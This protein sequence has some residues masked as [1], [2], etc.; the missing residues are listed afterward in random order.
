[1]RP[2]PLGVAALI[3][4]AGC[5][6]SQTGGE[7]RP[8]SP[9]SPSPQSAETPEPSPAPS[10]VDPR[11]EGFDIGFGEFAMALEAPAIRPG[12]V[13]F[14][15]RNGG[16][17]VHGF[18][19]EAEEEGGSSGPGGGDEGRFKVERP[20]F[21]PGETIRVDLD[22]SPGVYKIQC[23][24]ANH[25]DLGMETFLEVRAN[26]PK[27]R[28][29][30]ARED[31]VTIQGFAF[32]PPTIEVPAGAEVTW[33]N[34]DPTDHTVTAADGSF[35]SGPIAGGGTFSTTLSKQ[36]EFA[37]FCSIH[38]TMKGTVTVRA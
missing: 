17:L 26:A 11:K 32:D 33:L 29:D 18:E 2:G 28:Q 30:V 9:V 31:V 22:L 35:D 21:D 34:A 1:M 36:G 16:D 10:P 3:L 27:V 12:P 23:Y 24:V 38:P 15:I 14:V 37:Y 6:D 7:G 25:S 20:T 19:M 5:G 8:E 4:L 13:T